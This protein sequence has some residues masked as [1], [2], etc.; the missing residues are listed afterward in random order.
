[1][2][3]LKKLAQLGLGKKAR[4]DEK[5][6]TKKELLRRCHFEV[7]EQRRV[8]SADPVIAGVTYLEGDQGQDTTPDYFE[9]TFT[10]GAD[11]TQLTQFTIN[12][13]QDLSGNLSDG[14]MFFDVGS[15]QPGTGGFHGFTFD[16]RSTGITASDIVGVSVSADGLQLTVDVKNFEAGDKL[17]FSIDV[18]EVERFRTDKIASGVEFE[19]S[20]FNTTFVDEHYNFNART[21]NHV[22]PLEGGFN[23]NQ[24]SGIFFDTYDGLLAEA[25]KIGSGTLDLTGDNENGEADRTAATIDAYDLVPKPITIS[26]NVYHDENIN[27]V[28]DGT[29]DGIGNV[30]IN[31][32]KFNDSTNAYETVA[33]TT[34]DSNGRYEFGADLNLTPG[35]YRLVEVQPDGYLDVGASA[36]DVNGSKVGTV[37]DDA[38][39]NQNIISDINIPLGGT[40]A[41]DYDFKEVRPA[42]LE[43]SVWHDE[44]NDGVFDRGE[45]GIANV[46]IQVNRLGAKDTSVAD[47]FAGM[48]S[49]F[50]RTDSEGRYHVDALPP[51]IYEIIEVNNDPA[52]GNPLAAFIDGKDSIGRVGGVT[53]GTQSNDRFTAIELCADDKGVEYNF[54][55]IKPASIGGYVSVT[56]PEGDCLDPTDPNHVGIAGVEI[57]LYGE[58]GKLVASTLTNDDG[59]YEFDN[60]APGVY[61]VVEVQP[62]G[63]L[64]GG[65]HLGKV[66]GATSGI[67]AT[68]DTFAGIVLSS[69]SEGTNYNFCEHVPA[70]LSGTV[71]HDQNNDG[72]RDAGEDTI[73]NVRIQLFNDKGDLIAEEVTDSNG[74]YSFDNLMPGTYKVTEIQP[75]SYVDGKDSLGT[76]SG[77]SVGDVTNDMFSSITLGGG[78]RGV[79]YDFG[80]IRHGSISGRVHA[81]GNGNCV[82]DDDEGDRPLEGVTLILLNSDNEEVARTQT[83]ENGEYFFDDLEPGSY[84]IREFTPDGYIDGSE[85]AGNLGGKVTDDRIGDIVISSGQAGVNYDFC[86]HIPA[87]LHGTVYHDENNDGVQ[88]DGE[89]GIGKTVVKLFDASGN[90]VAETQTM[91]NG[92]YWFTGLIPGTYSVQEIQ[93][94]GYVDGIDSIG[95]NG[96]SKSNDLFTEVRLQGGDKAVNYDFGEILLSEITG[97]VHADGNGNCTFEDGDQPL[98]GVTLELLDQDGKVIATTTTDAE[99]N[100]RFGD[101]LPGEYSVREVQPDGYFSLGEHAGDGGGVASENLISGIKVTSG[102]KLTHYD[103]CEEAPAEIRGRVWE[104]GPAFQNRDGIL[105]ANYRE[106]R[107]GIYQEGTDRPLEGVRMQL[108][109][110]LDPASGDIEPRPVTLGEVMPEFYSHLGTSDSNAP[111][112]VETSATG[113]YSFKGLR[114]G[115]YIVLETQPDGLVDSNDTPG[116]TTGFTYNSAASTATAQSAVIRVFSTEQIMDSVVNIRVNAGGLSVANNFSEVSVLDDP[117]DP[118]TPPGGE[119]PPSG[120]PITPRPGL[121]GLPGLFGAQPGV[122][123]QLVGP[124]RGAA[125]QVSAG[126]EYTWH[127]SVING[128]SPRAVGEATLEGS[129]WLQASFMTESDWT[130]F[131]MSQ[132]YWSFSDSVTKDGEVLDSD[133]LSHRFGML[134]GK[135]LAGDFDGDGIDEVAIFK[136][137]YWMIDINRNGQWDAE[138]LMARLGDAEDQAVVGDWDGDGKDDI[139]I[140]G[141]IWERDHAAIAR[142]PGLPNPENQLASKPKNIPPATEDSTTGARIMR[143]SAYGKQRADVIDHVFGVD[144]Y[145]K[146]AV[147]GD[148]NGNGIRSIG[149]FENGSWRL[150]VNGDGE[151]DYEDVYASFGRAGDIPVVGDFDG[152][153]VEQIAIYRSGTWIVDSNQNYQLD[154]TDQ[155]FEYGD[156]TDQPVAGDWDGDGTDEPALYRQQQAW[157]RSASRYS[158]VKNR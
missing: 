104:D 146:I 138:D 128:G 122:F 93:P 32:Q 115:S 12:G 44:N 79:N 82:F 120:N 108:Y 22:E 24:Q 63:Y 43:G 78:E 54:G 1:M 69:G 134:N 34:T 31:L 145:E 114:A 65:E 142:D 133:R 18:D 59:H 28:H 7:M 85:H 102:Q 123:T 37:S 91:D 116:S 110:Y 45:Q 14:D 38:D 81:D 109:Y 94:E 17:V 125:F 68:N 137:G 56:T 26:G 131:D 97:R 60:L 143:L 46:L 124:N 15:E 70:G 141:P 139:G 75:A 86:E 76:V 47:P 48:D 80:E 105:P 121:A 111:V 98:D 5:H 140:Y 41:T 95:S 127:L 52:G 33:S 9:V 83:D 20:F 13:D 96:G 55:E 158:V 77:V 154:A 99:G 30:L 2:G 72:V 23:Q 156:A 136:D 92:E 35:N 50:I 153:G 53:V 117:G 107:D 73:A 129:P 58:D 147:T 90:L 16:T 8:L 149:T 118:N 112:W 103:F 157:G 155:T 49:I 89:E 29:E 40:A 74:R 6:D 150:D 100:Y 119:D 135:A 148:W 19:G 42:S 11:T 21:I 87:E 67:L 62:D 66:D 126:P 71:W 25:A 39:G 151:F 51:G 3:F 10:G 152:D 113:E 101:L 88:N 132:G 27:C 4:T 106:L 84:S 61:T 64:D 36:G 144:E 57:Q 130:Q